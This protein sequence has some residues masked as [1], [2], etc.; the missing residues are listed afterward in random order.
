MKFLRELEEALN[1]IKEVEER[2]K[3]IK[4]LLEPKKVHREAKE[5]AVLELITALFRLSKAREILQHIFISY[6]MSPYD[7]EE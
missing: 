3:L 1:Y 6:Y 4:H 5:R 7:W 2:L